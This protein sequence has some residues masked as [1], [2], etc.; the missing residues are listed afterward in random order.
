[1]QDDSLLVRQIIAGDEDAFCRLVR[2]HYESVYAQTLSIVHNP[3]DAE[4]LTNDVF[5]KVYLNISRLRRISSFH[6]WLRQIARNHC[7]HW[8]RKHKERHLYLEEVSDETIL[9]R[10]SADSELI[11]QERIDRTLEAVRS[12]PKMDRELIEG[13]YLDDLSY[14][15]LQGRHSLSEAAVRM[16]LLRARQKVRERVKELLSASAVFRWRKVLTRGG[17]EA[18]KLGMKTKLVI[19]GVGILTLLGGVGVL[20]RQDHSITVHYSE[21]CWTDLR[22]LMLEPKFRPMRGGIHSSSKSIA[23]QSYQCSMAIKR[24]TRRREDL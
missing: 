2:E 6:K 8:L 7:R 14:K 12:L 11:R 18:M 10:D 24:S 4:E 17:L 16:R 9:H 15:A 13:F 19:A 23:E 21:T 3:A 5:V 20:M 1:M 22:I